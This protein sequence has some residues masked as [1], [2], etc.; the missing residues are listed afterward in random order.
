MSESATCL[1]LVVYNLSLNRKFY[2]I[3][4]L[5][6]RLMLTL[7]AKYD[8]KFILVFILQQF[9]MSNFTFNIVKELE[10]TINL[11]FFISKDKL[12]RLSAMCS[13]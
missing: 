9:G 1:Q 2:E 11:K 3:V 6:R 7:L 10:N 8:W 12:K 4:Q 5:L 13:N